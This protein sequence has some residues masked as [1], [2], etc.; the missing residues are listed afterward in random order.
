M[1]HIHLKVHFFNIEHST[2]FKIFVKINRC[3]L[4]KYYRKAG[5]GMKPCRVTPTVGLVVFQVMWI[6]CAFGVEIPYDGA[7]SS[8]DTLPLPTL[9]AYFEPL[10]HCAPSSQTSLWCHSWIGRHCCRQAPPQT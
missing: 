6:A 4:T 7:V 8:G 5:V 10:V 1:G 9:A 3:D 2:D